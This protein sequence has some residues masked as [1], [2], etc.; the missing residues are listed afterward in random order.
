[1]NR[2]VEIGLG[3]FANRE[4]R[5]SEAAGSA[6]GRAAHTATKKNQHIKLEQPLRIRTRKAGTVL[7][8]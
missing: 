8:S 4:N 5:A 2:M 1:M 6:A 7:N 3:S